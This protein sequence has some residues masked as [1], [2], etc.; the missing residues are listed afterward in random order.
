[1]QLKN[2]DA[3]GQTEGATEMEEDSQVSQDAQTAEEDYFQQLQQRVQLKNLDANGQTEGVAEI[4]EDSQVSQE[5][6]S[7]EE[8]YFQQLQQRANKRQ[9]TE[10]ESK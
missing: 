7:S 5:V 4:E 10:D 9:K 8:D 1:V 2:L 3:N 6:N